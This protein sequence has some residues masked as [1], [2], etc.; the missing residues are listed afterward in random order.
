MDT[1]TETSGSP[2][3]LQRKGRLWVEGRVERN[4]EDPAAEAEGSAAKS[5]NGRN[6]SLY[7]VRISVRGTHQLLEDATLPPPPPP[8]F[9]P[10]FSKVI[11][12]LN[13]DVM[14]SRKVSIQT[15][16]DPKKPVHADE[17][18]PSAIANGFSVSPHAF[19]ILALGLL[20]EKQQLQKAPEEE[21]MF[22]FYHKASNSE[23]RGKMFDT[24]K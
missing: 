22:D 6:K 18:R 3:A 7:G 16:Q 24:V 1:E 2:R 8:E 23:H 9:C 12:L 11:N 20:E 5:I 15:D 10:A 13:C 21:V 19:H 14:M 17:T 4:T